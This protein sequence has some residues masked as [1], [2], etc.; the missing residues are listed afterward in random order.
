MVVIE[1]AVAGVPAGMGMN[2]G[3]ELW[4]K[5]HPLKLRRW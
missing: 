5:S 3:S 4:P 2:A 1:S